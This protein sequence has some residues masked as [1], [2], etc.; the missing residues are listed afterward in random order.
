MSMERRLSKLEQCIG[1][2]DDAYCR[3]VIVAPNSWSDADRAA[4]ERAEI[5]HDG[6]LH[7][8][9]IETYSGVR[10]QP[11]RG[12]R[13]HINIMIVPAPHAVEEADE[14]TRATWRARRT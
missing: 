11:C 8:D 12:H 14:A 10:P 2:N 4:W 5:L 9:L 3:L 7:D 1:S 6:A 13:P